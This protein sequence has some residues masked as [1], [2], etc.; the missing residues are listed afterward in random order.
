MEGLIRMSEAGGCERAIWYRYNGYEPQFTPRIQRAIEDGNIHEQYILD[1]ASQNLPGAPYA[2]VDQQVEVFVNK[3]L[4]GHYDALMRN[5]ENLVIVEAKALSRQSFL[6]F[7]NKPIDV[8]FRRY[9]IQTL[10]Y[11]YASNIKLGYIVARNVDTPKEMPYEHWYVELRLDEHKH[12]IER[13]L[14][15]LKNLK[16][17]LDLGEEIER[18]F[19]PST[20]TICKYCPFLTYCATKEEINNIDVATLIDDEEFV[21]IV[22]RYAELKNDIAALENEKKELENEANKLKELIE[23]RVTNT[24]VVKNYLVEVKEIISERVDTKKV[25]QLLS[26]EVL[27]DVLITTSYKKINIKGI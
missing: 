10:L 14:E 26:Q 11:M 24:A 1:W 8:A 13:E 3:I 23:A 17:K 25:K 18:P 7:K 15:R 21:K 27:K 9:Y 6:E 16:F 5:E 20:D 12:V 22:E 2:F 4:S 19:N